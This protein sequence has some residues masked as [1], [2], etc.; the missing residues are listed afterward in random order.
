[1]KKKMLIILAT[2]MAVCMVAGCD[3]IEE[4]EQSDAAQSET[5][6]SDETGN[7]TVDE[8]ENE[9]VDE[10]S[11]DDDEESG[12]ESGSETAG[13][14]GSKKSKGAGSKLCISTKDVDGRSVNTSDVFAE[15]KITV[16]NLWA[17]WCGPCAG[18]IP[19]LDAMNEEL[20]EKGCAVVGFLTDGED[21][22]GLEDAKAIL[23][24]AG[25]SY[26]N[27]V[28]PESVLYDVGLEAF[29]TTFFVDSDGKILGDPVV[30]AYPD[31]YRKTV[32]K[33]LSNM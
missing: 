12:N 29:P 18:E 3:D 33:L 21:P 26:L 19:E 23:Q 13:D 2:V 22:E 11:G 24:D 20:K 10:T 8:T 15:N 14:T 30:G 28:C 25:V 31:Q 5:V 9:A 1:M 27:V 16:V 32:D 7:E 6:T 4:I 17:S